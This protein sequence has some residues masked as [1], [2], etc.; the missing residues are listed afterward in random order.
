MCYKTVKDILF[1]ICSPLW[2]EYLF[3]QIKYLAMI[4]GNQDEIKIK[5]FFHPFFHP[6]FSA[7]VVIVTHT[8]VCD[9]ELV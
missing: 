8:V 9:C 5:G 1:S 2:I 6:Q 3:V 4:L 7:V